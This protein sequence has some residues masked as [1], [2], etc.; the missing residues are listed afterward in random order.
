MN[1]K[2]PENAINLIRKLQREAEIKFK[3]EKESLESMNLGNKQRTRK[4]TYTTIDLLKRHRRAM[5]S[6][7]IWFNW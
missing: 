1:K 5:I 3:F 2:I 6:I 4:E 7:N